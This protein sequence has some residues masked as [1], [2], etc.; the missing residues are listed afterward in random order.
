MLEMINRL[1]ICKPVMPIPIQIWSDS[2]ADFDETNK[3]SG[4]F[5]LPSP[6]AP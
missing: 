2:D 3:Q 6:Q 1:K 5:S 4:S